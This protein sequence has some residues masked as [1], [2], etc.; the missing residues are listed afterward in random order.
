MIKDKG[1]GRAISYSFCK[2]FRI[3]EPFTWEGLRSHFVGKKSINLEMIPPFVNIK[4]QF[5]Y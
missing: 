1:R 3:R 5:T 4:S 2:N